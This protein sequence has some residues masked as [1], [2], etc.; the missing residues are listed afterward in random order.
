MLSMCFLSIE[1]EGRLPFFSSMYKK[2][3]MIFIHQQEGYKLPTSI[4]KPLST[5][6]T[7]HGFGIFFLHGWK[8]HN[9]SLHGWKCHICS[10]HGWKYRIVL[11][12]DENI[13]FVLFMD[14]NIV[15]VLF[16]DENII[17]ALFMDEN[18]TSWFSLWWVSSARNWNLL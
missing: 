2:G 6:I 13:I 15:I 9:C 14:E 5:V 18:M 8:Y 10:L 12:M 7:Y 11:F 4:L 17:I 1:W 3:Y 16:M